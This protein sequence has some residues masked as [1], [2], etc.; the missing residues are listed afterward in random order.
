MQGISRDEMPDDIDIL[1]YLHQTDNERSIGKKFD[2]EMIESRARQDAQIVRWSDIVSAIGLRDH[3]HMSQALRTH[4]LG[5]RPEYAD[6][7]AAD[8][9]LAY[10][11]QKQLFV[12]T[13]GHLQSAMHPG[14][15]KVFQ[16]CLYENVV[17]RDE[18]NDHQSIAHLDAVLAGVD[19]FEPVSGGGEVNHSEEATG[20]LVVAGGDSPIDLEMA[21][22]AL[23]AVTL[24]VK[25]PIMFDFHAAV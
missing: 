23:D 19:K 5:L 18:W 6:E 1:D 9:L 14:I 20:K 2:V 21:E 15:R 11:R 4:I 7:T 12:P 16:G 25:R 10:C 8:H 17:V 24:F 3:R 13:T 22:H